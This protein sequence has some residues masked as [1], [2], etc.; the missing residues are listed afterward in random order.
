[1]SNSK[2]LT[3]LYEDNHVLVVLKPPGAPS[4]PDKSTAPDMLGLLKR[5]LAIRDQKKGE[6]WLGLVHR[7]DRP[8]SGLMVFA[9]TSK[10]ASRMSKSFRGREVNKYYLARIRGIPD[11]EGGTFCDYLSAREIDGCVRLLATNSAS[12]PMTTSKS[13]LSDP[14]DVQLSEK[15]TRERLPDPSNKNSLP[16]LVDEKLAEPSDELFSPKLNGEKLTEPSDELFS[17]KLNGEKLA[18]PSDELFSPNLNGEKLAEP[19]DEL[20]SPKLNGEKRQLNDAKM[21][22]LTW[23]VIS[24]MNRHSVNESLLFVELLTGRRHQIRVQFAGRGFPILG[25]R[26][27]GY[28]DKRDLSV[29]TLALHACGLIFPHPVRKTTMAFYADPSINPSFCQ[30]DVD[31]FNLYVKSLIDDGKLSSPTL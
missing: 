12:D 5:H 10:A 19:S 1:M 16:E 11:Q 28:N 9:K 27:Y 30:D 18:E 31:A 22:E 15:N 21:A 7:L 13:I 14:S 2:Q 29:P 17:P 6:A 3:I 26:R 24:S 20:F 8:T 25:D 4:Q 23:A